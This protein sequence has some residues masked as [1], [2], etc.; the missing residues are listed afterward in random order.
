MLAELQGC[1]VRFLREPG[2]QTLLRPGTE[3]AGARPLLCLSLSPLW[4]PETAS[5]HT[6]H[7]PTRFKACR[8]QFL[9]WGLAR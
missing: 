5:N 1:Y 3:D 4:K 8:L 6:L 7:S 2:V 9:S